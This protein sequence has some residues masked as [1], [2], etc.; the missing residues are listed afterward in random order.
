MGVLG[1]IHSVDLEP[2]GSPCNSSRYPDIVP[3]VA[4][5]VSNETGSELGR[6]TLAAGHALPPYECDFD[7]VVANVGDATVYNF[8]I[9]GHGKYSLTYAL[10]KL[11]GW[12]VS[13]QL[14]NDDARLA[15]LGS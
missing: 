13:L 8:T 7:F 3:G 12:R 10:M 9:A 14:S 1:I 11:A 2:A 15:A 5:V 4:V 6:G